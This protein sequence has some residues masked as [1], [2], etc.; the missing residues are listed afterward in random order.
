MAVIVSSAKI[1]FTEHMRACFVLSSRISSFS[2]LIGS[3][4]YYV[5]VTYIDIFSKSHSY[6]VVR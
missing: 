3:S 1:V 4:F 5:N 6:G 2:I